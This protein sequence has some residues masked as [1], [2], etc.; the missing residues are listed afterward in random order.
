[1]AENIEIK[2]GGVWKS[3]DNCE[4]NVGGVWKDVDAIEIN[5]GGVWKTAW[6]SYVA[7]T[8]SAV[9]GGDTNSCRE[10]ICGSVT[11]G[12]RWNTDGNEYECTNAGTF[13]INIGQWLDTGLSSSVWVMFTRVSGK[14]HFD[15]KTS[16]TRYNIATNQTFSNTVF[17]VGADTITGY[18]RFYD[19]ATGGNL[20]DTTSSATWT[21]RMTADPCPICCF[22]PD[23]PVLMASG[24]EMPIGKIREGDMIAV[25][26]EEKNEI[27]EQAVT[28]VIARVN[29]PMYRLHF[30]SGKVLHAS[31]DHP[32]HVR[33]KGPASLNNYDTEY[34]DLGLPEQLE[35]GDFVTDTSGK[36]DKLV[37]IEAS[38]YPDTVFTL[39]NSLFYANGLLVY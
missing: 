22:T 15:S 36:P 24:L 31:D 9:A 7:P 8:V 26:D 32:F 3:I 21:A 11:A 4:I 2:P 29:R 6:T 12:V 20:L 10:D 28:E 18:F 25:F 35:L 14:T 13:N 17:S 16:G 34:K 38:P 39:G 30:A 37:R 1:M 5:V 33:G 19:A 27:I 23:T